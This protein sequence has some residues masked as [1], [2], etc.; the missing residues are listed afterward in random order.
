MLLPAA[1]FPFI[2]PWDGSLK[3]TAVD[4]SALNAAPAGKNGR[5]LTK[6]GHFVEANTGRRVRFM[7]TNI[8]TRAAFP[9]HADADRIATRLATLGFN[10]VRFHHI[11]NG[12]DLDGGSIWKKDRP[13]VEIDPKQL[14]K[15]DYFVAALKRQGVYTNLNLQTTRDYLPEMG[16][17]PEV[18]GLKDYAK[19]IDKV[20]RRMIALQKDYAK[21]LLDRKN[22]Y[23]GMAYRDDPALAFVE[24]NN[25][26]S[27][28]GWPNETPGQGIAEMP[29]YFRGEVQNAW[30][31]WLDRS[32]KDEAEIE[33]AW[34]KGIG[35]KG[36][37]LLD[38]DRPW[39]H[40][41]QGEGD[42][43]PIAPKANLVPGAAPP[44]AVDVRSNPGPDWHVQVHQTGL[45]LKEGDTYTVTFNASSSQT[46]EITVNAT[47]DEADWHNVGLSKK[48]ALTPASRRFTM[49]FGAENVRKD[50]ARLAFVLGGARGEVLISDVQIF[51]GVDG[52]QVTGRASDGGP[53]AIPDGGTAPQM[54]DWKRFLAETETAYSDEMRAYLR[55]D[56]GIKANL[57]DTQ[58]QWGGLTALTREAGSDFADAHFYWEHPDFPRGAWDPKDWT[59][60]NS[61]MVAAMARGDD[62]IFGLAR[63]RVVG[64]PYTVSEFNH[65][66]PSD[67]RV[68]TMPV[69]ASFAAAQDWDGFYLFEYGQTGTGMAN[70]RFGGFFDT[71]LDPV[72][73]AF[74]PAAALI[75]RGGGLPSLPARSTAVYPSL[76]PWES[77]P[78]PSSASPLE[79]RLGM[80]TAP[81]DVA[82]DRRSKA[83]M[84]RLDLKDSVW[85]FSTLADA[86]VAGS[87]GDVGGKTTNAGGVRF[88]FP[89]GGN[90]FAA[91]TITALDRKPLNV[92]SRALL[93]IANR[94]ENSDMAWNAARTTVGEGWGKGPTLAEGVVSTVT[95]STKS[96][97]AVWALDARGRRSAKVP[98]KVEKGRLVFRTDPKYRT[99]WYE[100][101]A[102]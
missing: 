90:G 27:L 14:D 39:S 58:I 64:K 29:P 12:W 48:I 26:N 80:T 96:L 66:A 82:L 6:G 98:S 46:T 42:V 78:T 28:V 89:K 19:K 11:Q 9:T 44:F 30:N 32:Y 93:T 87:V 94:A 38:S 7:G 31:A 75:F 95:L 43:R 92:S 100:I 81:K 65:P 86:K 10:V 17:P 3:G 33:A 5:I 13:M 101:A 41:N 70:D 63:T 18:K 88:V 60:R 54:R 8:T 91:A 99:L 40:E 73:A 85:N 24:I 55:T 67:Y 61:S 51:P 52:W 25:E 21:S 47:L 50:H 59:V 16:F 45:D 4:V 35:A 79:T 62:D 102:K 84:P 74:F 20:D 77:S 57:I 49:V 71:A 53:Y 97:R 83:V 72:K 37:D 23:T 68:E 69:L 2:I 15:L 34:T 1:W 56:L 76:R 36:A 22:P